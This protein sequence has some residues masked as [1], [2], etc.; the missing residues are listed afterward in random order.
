MHKFLCLAVIIGLAACAEL[1]GGYRIDIEQGN[2]VTQDMI[3]QLKPGMSK[4][5]VRFVMGT[6]LIKDTFHQQRW[7]YIY[8]LE[9]GGGKR[10]QKTL[11]MLFNDEGKLLSWSGD[12]LSQLDGSR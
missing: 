9:R 1:P 5:Q 12:A 8:S 4:R 6:P 3:K 11:T 7:D 10:T 2:I